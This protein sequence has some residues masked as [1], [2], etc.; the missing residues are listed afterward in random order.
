MP[1]EQPMIADVIDLEPG[2]DTGLIET[3]ESGVRSRVDAGRSRKPPPRLPRTRTVRR[4][5]LAGRESRRP[6]QAGW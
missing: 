3:P 5:A 1:E 4:A 2:D 6:R